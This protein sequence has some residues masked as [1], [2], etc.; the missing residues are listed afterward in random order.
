MTSEVNLQVI[1]DEGERL[2]AF[3]T[4]DPERTVP[5]YPAWT[6][7]DLI[8]H[9][10]SIHGRTVT[11]CRKLPTERV[12]APQLPEGRDPFDWY[13]LNLSA[14]IEALEGAEP[15]AEVW[16]FT[17]PHNVSTWERRMV[18]ETGLHRWDAQQAV[19]DP[20]PLLDH[21]A[22]SGLDEF[23]L[24]W[25]PRLTDLPALEFVAADTKG[26][27]KFG[28][29]EATTVTGTGSDLFL[30]LMARPGVELPTEWAAAVNSLR[31]P[32]D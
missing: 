18:I 20:D 30:R 24:M 21:V 15:E 8:T 23:S 6:L 25:L 10:A 28:D 3:A 14:M 11:I 26:S 16:S 5:Q 27:W 17:P 29:G 9:V 1:A 31:S 19:E 22:V 13:Q 2:L 7:R 4:V 32:A 12:P